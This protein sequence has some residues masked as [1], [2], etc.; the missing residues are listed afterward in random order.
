MPISLNADTVK[1]S[2]SDF[3][4]I[5]YK[6]MAEIFEM[7][8]KLGRLFDEEVY[9]N[10]LAARLDEI[11]TEVLIDVSF[12]NFHKH[13]F[14]DALVSKGAI[15]EFKTVESLHDRNRGQLLN[16]LLLSGLRHG[17]LVNLRPDRV[18]HEFVNALVSKTE[19]QSFTVDTTNW[20][21]APGFGYSETRLVAD[22][23]RDWGTGLERYLYEEAI[24]HFLGGNEKVLQEI[25][26]ILNKR[27]VARQ[28]TNMR[29]P[30]IGIRVTTL[31]KNIKR[32]RKDL[33][34]FVASTDLRSM[35][36]INITLGKLTFETIESCPV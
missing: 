24:V 25:D 34:Q 5:S 4:T 19:R 3:S 15:F 14:I 26:V 33:I 8:D 9:K 20:K 27:I 12:D 28:T 21:P 10:A 17:K 1:L 35:Q 13:Y 31:E 6:V 2:Q 36:W 11:T 7:H 16:Y 32:Y 23:L 29:A 18:E 30:N 22:I